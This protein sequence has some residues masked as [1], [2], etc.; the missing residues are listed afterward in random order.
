MIMSR[1]MFLILL[2]AL[3]MI[4]VP[5]CSALSTTGSAGPTTTQSASEV[6]IEGFAFKPATLTVKVGTTVTW[7]NNDS[8]AHNIKSDTFNSPMLN[9]GDKFEFTF[10][11][12]GTFDYICGVHPT[13]KGQ[14]IVE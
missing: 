10:S 11:T 3:T 1:N 6:L 12:T 5:A 7:L 4:L 8:T 13:M 14:I 2:L 9:K